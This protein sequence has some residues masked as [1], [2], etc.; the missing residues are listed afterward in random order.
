MTLN[1][2]DDQ[3]QGSRVP[4]LLACLLDYL[5]SRGTW[6]LVNWFG[7]INVNGNLNGGEGRL[8]NNRDGE[9]VCVLDW[10]GLTLRKGEERGDGRKVWRFF[11][12]FDLFRH[13]ERK[14]TKGNKQKKHGQNTVL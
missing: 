1:S 7:R 11:D 12:F 6:D 9:R 10:K 3:N 2:S 8:K 5:W 4:C 14:E 13:K